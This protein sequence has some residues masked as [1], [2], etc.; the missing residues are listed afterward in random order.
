MIVMVSYLMSFLP[1]FVVS[2]FLDLLN[3]PAKS[4]QQ[5]LILDS[6]S[7]RILYHDQSTQTKEKGFKSFLSF[8]PGLVLLGRIAAE[9]DSLCISIYIQIT[10]RESGNCLS[11]DLVLRTADGAF[12]SVSKTCWVRGTRDQS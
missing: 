11:S 9:L 2:F 5:L 6:C 10:E 7:K 1:S 12:R 4:K 3:F 8:S